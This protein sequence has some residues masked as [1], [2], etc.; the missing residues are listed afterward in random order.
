[1]A[2]LVIFAV[3]AGAGTAITPGVIA[4]LVLT[5]TFAI[6]AL[7]SVIDGVGLA[8]GFVRTAAIVV[9]AGCGLALIWP[10][11]GTPVERAL[12]PLQRLG[13][14]SA[15]SGFWSGLLVGGALGFLYAPCAGPILAAVISVSATQGASAEL[16]VLAL[17]YGAGSAA[18]LLAGLRRPPDRR[19]DT[20]GGPSRDRAAHAGRAP[21]RHRGGDGRRARRALPD[22]ARRRAAFGRIEPDRRA[23]ALGRRG[24]AVERPARSAAVPLEPLRG[25]RPPG[26]GPAGSRPRTRLHRQRGLV[27]HEA[28][29][30][31]A[32]G[33]PARPRRP[34]RLLDLHLH[35]LPTY[36]PAAA[37]VA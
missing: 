20:A 7:A 26:S 6:V 36:P 17:A 15:G 32:P 35:Q 12:A 4:G 24:T 5:H 8:D 33:R 14:R 30:A 25:A 16:V 9:L 31:L 2:L 28:R 34:G 1:M 21:D 19:A 22:G 29:A 13:T 10:R 27:P 3:L 18:V 23:R 11:L 37:R